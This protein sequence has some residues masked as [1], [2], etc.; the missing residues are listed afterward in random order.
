MQKPHYAALFVAVLGCLTLFASCAGYDK[1][2]SAERSGDLS[3]V[4][5][6]RQRPDETRIAG[7]GDGAV[8]AAGATALTRRPYLQQLTAGSALVAFRASAP[9]VVVDVTRQ[10]GSLVTSV[11]ATGDASVATVDGTWLGIARIQG[12]QSSTLYCYALRGLTEP[13]G[14]QTAPAPGSDEAVRFIAF[15]DSG[16][17]SAEQHAVRDQMFTVPFDLVLHTGDLAYEDGR[18]GE[19]E[20]NFFGVYSSLIAE[21][22]VF[23]VAGNHDY[24]TQD[25]L[26]FRQA[27]M[28]PENGA[29]KGTERWYSFDWGNVHF[30][31]LDTEKTDATQ[32]AW[33]DRDLSA[34]DQPW[35][36]VFAH[37]PPFSSGEHG[38][39]P[40]F[41]AHFAPVIQKH[42]VQLVL[43]GHDHDYERTRPLAGTT[44]VVTGGGG[45]GT[46]S[47][48]TSS[49]TAFSEDV[50]HFVQVEVGK[51]SLTLHAIDGTGV[52]FDSARIPR[53]PVQ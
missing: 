27:F 47:V 3:Y 20:Q 31:G 41:V 26:P 10:D 25:A 36:I 2:L 15:G 1:K 30:V 35:K 29:P 19:L 44:Y 17:G 32:A 8:T 38:S 11:A 52:E 23:P 22:P 13:A 7:C 43:S 9:E 16:D 28:L 50:L 4:L 48:G 45:R 18:S 33:L 53:E 12:L 5:D 24:A 42:G 51:D 34:T 49:F 21:F 6:V 40:A 14:F 39:D 37:E 46:R